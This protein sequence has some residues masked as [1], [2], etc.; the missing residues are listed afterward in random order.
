MFAPITA[1]HGLKPVNIY[2]IPAVKKPSSVR[3][4]PG[5]PTLG[6]REG[7][8]GLFVY[9]GPP[10]HLCLLPGPHR[11]R[12]RE[13]NHYQR[14]KQQRHENRQRGSRHHLLRGCLGSH[15]GLRGLSP[16][17]PPPRLPGCLPACLRQVGMFFKKKGCGG[18]VLTQG[19]RDKTQEQKQLCKH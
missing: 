9:G 6:G 16:S 15:A 10:R 2:E 14:E 3:R 19:Q 8:T 17:L 12:R 5:N 11:E 18:A 7:G 13:N 1:F 4:V